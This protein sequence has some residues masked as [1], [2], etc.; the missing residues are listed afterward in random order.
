[1]AKKRRRLPPCRAPAPVLPRRPSPAR[2][3][4]WGQPLTRRSSGYPQTPPVSPAAFRPD[5][6]DHRTDRP[7][8]A[9]RAVPCIAPGEAP[10]GRR[11]PGYDSNLELRPEG[12]TLAFP[13]ARLPSCRARPSP[14]RGVGVPPTP[15]RRLISRTRHPRRSYLARLPS[16]PTPVSRPAAAPPVSRVSRRLHPA[17][18]RLP[19]DR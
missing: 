13:H 8:S 18:S 16:C 3:V 11:N 17:I 15:T 9:R 2:T 19:S 7:S 5:Q 6:S 14:G 4:A 12:A 10:G 1:M